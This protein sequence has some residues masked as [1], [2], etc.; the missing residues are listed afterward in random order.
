MNGAGSEHISPTLEDVLNA[1][2]MDTS[3]Q[4]ALEQ[5]PVQTAAL[6]NTLT[7]AIIHV[8]K[9]PSV[10]I[11]VRNIQPTIRNALDGAKKKKLSP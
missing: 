7:L 6:L 11:A 5:K 4:F 3:A 2:D 1:K 10:P 9:K 8:N